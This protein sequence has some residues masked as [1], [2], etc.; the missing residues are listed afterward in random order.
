MGDGI[1][2]ALKKS[3]ENDVLLPLR[4]WR[5]ASDIIVHNIDLVIEKLRRNRDDMRS[6]ILRYYNQ[7]LT[8]EE[9]DM[10]VI[11]LNRIKSDVMK[12]GY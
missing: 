8:D 5:L 1:T 9:L 11:A 2:D 4:I 12:I 6:A 10:L 3:R 7:L